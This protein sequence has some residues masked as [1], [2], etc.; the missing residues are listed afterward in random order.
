MKIEK[1]WLP[2]ALA[3]PLVGVI[4]NIGPAVDRWQHGLDVFEFGLLVTMARWSAWVLL[5]PLVYAIVNRRSL[6]MLIGGGFVVSALHSA[7]IALVQSRF[8]DRPLYDLQHDLLI[9]AVTAVAC[10]IAERRMRAARIAAAD[11]MAERARPRA[12]ASS[13]DRLRDLVRSDRIAAERAIEEFSDL[14]RAQLSDL[15]IIDRMR[16]AGMA[17]SRATALLILSAATVATMALLS[18]G[19]PAI[20]LQLLVFVLVV[21][22]SFLLIDRSPLSTAEL[23]MLRQQ[24]SPHFLFNSLNSISA[25]LDRSAEQAEEMLLRLRRFYELSSRQGEAT[26]VPLSTELEFLRAYLAVESVRFGSR[27][28]AR[29]EIDDA[30]LECPVPPLMLQTLVENAVRHGIARRRD[31]GAITIAASVSAGELAITVENDV[32]QQS[33]SAKQGIGLQNTRARLRELYGNRGTLATTLTDRFRVTVTLPAE[34][35]CAH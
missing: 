17:Q 29:F 11:A 9:Y 26:T 6:A 20:S 31:G 3:W 15:P 35:S 14:L 2:I 5:V 1:T 21:T 8:P 28:C 16:A 18:I 19:A 32:A 34:E 4:V 33:P 22:S 27:L 30:A 12:I 7:M 23:G 25:L 10:Y 24:L 13:L